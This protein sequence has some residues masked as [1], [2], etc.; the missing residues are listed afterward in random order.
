M[1]N[2]VWHG[3]RPD[4]SF[5]QTSRYNHD[6]AVA[7]FLQPLCNRRLGSHR[8]T[9]TSSCLGGCDRRL[10][11]KPAG[12]VR[13]GILC[14]DSGN[15]TVVWSTHS[16]GGKD[17]ERVD[18]GVLQP[19]C[20]PQCRAAGRV[21]RWCIRGRRDPTGARPSTARSRRRIRRARP[22]AH[23]GG[24]CAA[25]SY[26]H[27]DLPDIR[28]FLGRPANPIQPSG[29]FGAKPVLDSHRVLVRSLSHTILNHIAGGIPEIPGRACHLLAEPSVAG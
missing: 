13:F 22:L 1:W 9:S 16:V 14:R 25:S 20:G 29:P 4:D 27:N 7:G 24:S 8:H 18:D 26:V 15:R 17:V 3:R 12:R 5:W 23:V 11:D 6:H 19:D 28:Y 2:F 10:A 21:E